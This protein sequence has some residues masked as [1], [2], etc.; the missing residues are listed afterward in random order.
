MEEAKNILFASNLSKEMET[1]FK[2]AATTAVYHKSRIIVVHVMEEN[3]RSQKRMKTAF[4]EQ[5]YEDLKS[6]HRQEARNILTGKNVDALKIR[7]AI[8]GFFKEDAEVNDAPDLI[9]KILVTESPGIA[10]EIAAIAVEENCGMIVMGCKQQG[11]LAN[12]MGDH[13]VRKVLKRTSVPV[14]MVPLKR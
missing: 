4:G 5:L 9:S 11:L 2:H 1:V 8:A 14:L 13:V 7:Q 6:E 12:A 3:D 10:D